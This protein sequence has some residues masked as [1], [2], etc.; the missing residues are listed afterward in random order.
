[1]LLTAEPMFVF[2]YWSVDQASYEKALK[3]AGPSSKMTLRFYDIT[4]SLDLARAPQWDLDIFD[5]A[6]NWYLKREHPHQKLCFDLG[7]KN[8]TGDFYPVC[9]SNILHLPTPSLTTAGPA[10]PQS[11]PFPMSAEE[12]KSALGPY[13]FE[14]FEKGRM[15]TIANTSLAGIFHDIS[16]LRHEKPAAGTV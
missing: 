13:F 9:R 5:F 14:L 1:M 8:G 6:G 3:H 4:S 15:S 7:I 16:L 10:A 12:L 11:P 2:V